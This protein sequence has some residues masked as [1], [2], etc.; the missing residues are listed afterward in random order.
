MVTAADTQ[1]MNAPEGLVFGTRLSVA[2]EIGAEQEFPMITALELG[3]LQEPDQNRPSL[4]LRRCGTDSLWELAKASGSTVAAIREA[5]G[6][7]G[8]PVAEQMLL[9]PVV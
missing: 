6:L 3:E 8:E 9:I 2:M 7:A 1:T 4:I 5:N